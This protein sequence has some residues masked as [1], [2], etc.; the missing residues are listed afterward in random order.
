MNVFLWI[1]QVILAMHTVMGALWKFSNSEQAVPVLTAIPHGIWLTLGVLELL[2]AL[3]LILP[4]FNKRLAALAPIAAIC[5]AAEMLCFCVL[6]VQSGAAGY[7]HPIYWLVVA[8]VCAVV[9]Y[10]RLRLRPT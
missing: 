7:S 5:I 1:L 6:H 4:A 2:L 8:A 3:G 10:G 9:A